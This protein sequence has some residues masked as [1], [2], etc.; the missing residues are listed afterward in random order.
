MQPTVRCMLLGGYLESMEK[1]L[2]MR[3]PQPHLHH[4]HP[5][6][7]A[8]L[9]RSWP[10]AEIR[11]TDTQLQA[12]GSTMTAD[13]AMNDSHLQPDFSISAL[14]QQLNGSRVTLL[15][16]QPARCCVDLTPAKRSP[17]GKTQRSTRAKA[18][19]QER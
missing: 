6:S 16:S 15:C 5:S 3:P 12:P 18:Y 17:N 7:S 8:T 9:R 13:E 2:T 1:G 11:L 10:Q 19:G 4:K 14:L